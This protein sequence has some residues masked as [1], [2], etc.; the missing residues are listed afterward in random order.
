MSIPNFWEKT[1]TFLC[2]TDFNILSLLSENINNHFM[3]PPTVNDVRIILRSFFNN[4]FQYHIIIIAA[5]Q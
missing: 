5:R 2:K 1:A 3:L 4:I